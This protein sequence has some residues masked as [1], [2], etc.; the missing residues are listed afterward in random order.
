MDSKGVKA[1]ANERKGGFLTGLTGFLLGSV[2][3]TVVGLLIAPQSGKETREQIRRRTDEA[4]EKS[5]E[6]YTGQKERLH[7][8]IDAGRQA[9]TERVGELR[10]KIDEARE[11]LKEQ[12]ETATEFAR[13]KMGRPPK[14]E[15]K[16]E[17]KGQKEA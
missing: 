9:A 10:G 7:E 1:M 8:A 15:D 3:G 6:L 16:E 5:R 12:V 4:I 17:K 13:E 11:R 2:F 14:K